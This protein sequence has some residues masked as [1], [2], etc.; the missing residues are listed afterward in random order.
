MNGYKVGTVPLSRKQWL[1]LCAF[2]EANDFEP[3]LIVEVK[4]NG[5]QNLYHFIKR[6]QVDSKLG[7][8]EAVNIRIS[9][10]DVP[11]MSIH[12]YREGVPLV[13]SFSL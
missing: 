4:I 5:S 8:T 7:S 2:G 9:V 1:A 3:L 6:D 10:H 13:G 11:I 12:N